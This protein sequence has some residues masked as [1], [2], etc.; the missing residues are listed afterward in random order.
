MNKS[1]SPQFTRQQIEN[2]PTEEIIIWMAT[3]KDKAD[4]LADKRI[5][6]QGNQEKKQDVPIPRQR[7][8]QFL[9]HGPNS[10]YVRVK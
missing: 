1:N 9:M 10:G 7:S 8:L 4:A 2:M 6:S 5:L 3:F